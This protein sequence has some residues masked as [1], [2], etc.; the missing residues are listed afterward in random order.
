MANLFALPLPSTAQEGVWLIVDFTIRPTELAA[1]ADLF[2]QHI[3]DGRRD[4]GNL[5][6]LLLHDAD[7]P[8]RF[9]TLEVWTDQT[10]IDAHDATDHHATFLKKLSAIQ[11]EEKKVRTYEW[12][13]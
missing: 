11:A 4:P 10:A 6:F 7:E 2:D 13:K 9:T 5:L 12:M 8:T 1:A 3:L